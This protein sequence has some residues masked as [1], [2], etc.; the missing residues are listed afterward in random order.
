[1]A[2]STT[3]RTS[4]IAPGGLWEKL[5]WV[6]LPL[7]GLAVAYGVYRFGNVAGILL[8]MGAFGAILLL[9]S[10][11]FPKVGFYSAII[12]SFFLFD[13]QRFLRS[14]IP[15][16]T[17]V[18]LLVYIC[19][20]G[21][22]VRKIQVKESFWQHCNH[23]IVFVYVL[24]F[25]YSVIEIFNPMGAPF[26][27]SFLI[28]RRFLTLILFL[29]CS[30]QLFRTRD[31][32]VEFLKIYFIFI[33]IAALYGCYQEWFGYPAYEMRYIMSNPLGER[34]LSLGGGK[35]RK[36]SFLASPADYGLLMA[37]SALF[38]LVLLLN[39][40]FKWKKRTI[41]AV[42]LILCALAMGYSGTR[43]ATLML[44]I[45]I[46]LYVLMTLSN[47]KTLVF[48]SIF[49]LL[50]VFLI[51]GPIY[52][53]STINRLR[54]AFE[55]NEDESVQVRDYNRQ[56]I[57][58]FIYTHPLGGGLGTAGVGSS[59]YVP[60]HPLADFPSD[61]G[62]LRN[63][64]EYGWVGLLILY[65]TYIVVLQ[66][67]VRAY[68]KSRDPFN[69]VLLLASVVTLFSYIVAQYSQVAIGMIPGAFL[70]YPLIAILVRLRQIELSG[71][72]QS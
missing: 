10:V 12:I 46:V 53:N 68:Y 21:I 9:A 50:F 43:T 47:P 14:D 64:I 1:M 67:G 42:T 56:R 22:I 26:S 35:Y 49:G 57:Q 4:S 2:L 29:Y 69:R 36:F 3:R 27:V 19:F 59:A 58:P 16:G 32:I 40:K 7:L 62:L 6:L 25:L 41:T 72:K 39:A 70:V 48:T 65:I 55:P 28:Y 24:V 45:G 17:L 71:L 31:D 33:F 23:P 11:L 44:V 60:N 15:L 37:A 8:I 5:L 54:T 63:A 61:S 66:Q 34:L 13:I 20:L 51:Y 18:D 38:L 52:G 30:I